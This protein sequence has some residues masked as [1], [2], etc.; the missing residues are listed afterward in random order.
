MTGGV[1]RLA[2]LPA[3]VHRAD[4]TALAPP[5]GPVFLSLPGDVLTSEGN[6]QEAKP[7]GAPHA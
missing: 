3:A 7:S 4:K 6:E 1:G 5:T 2:P